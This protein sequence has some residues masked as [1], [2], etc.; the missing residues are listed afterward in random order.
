MH[1]ARQCC[2]RMGEYGLSAPFSKARRLGVLL[3]RARLRR[4]VAIEA[5]P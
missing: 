5:R 4:R 1:M 3:D 2:E